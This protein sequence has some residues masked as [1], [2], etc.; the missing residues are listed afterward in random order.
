MLF[1]RCWISRGSRARRTTKFAETRRLV[2]EIFVVAVVVVSIIVV[3]RATRIPPCY[4]WCPKRRRALFAVLVAIAISIIVVAV[5]IVVWTVASIIFLF[6]VIIVVVISRTGRRRIGAH[7]LHFL[8]SS[9]PFTPS[10]ILFG[11]DVCYRLVIMLR[12][13]DVYRERRH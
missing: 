11:I 9:L 6:V 3:S 13:V 7:W 8:S 1:L 2:V 10:S 5:I 4:N 12:T